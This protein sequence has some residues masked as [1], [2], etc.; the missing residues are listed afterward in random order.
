ME[1]RRSAAEL[2]AVYDG[3]MQGAK[4]TETQHEM[5]KAISAAGC[6]A[7]A[8]FEQAPSG[9]SDLHALTRSFLLALIDPTHPELD[10][11]RADPAA[12]AVARDAAERLSK[13]QNP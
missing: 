11:L 8:A 2:L 10:Y 7:A 4:L 5:Q 6:F 3:F 12:G 9:G 1:F 13:I